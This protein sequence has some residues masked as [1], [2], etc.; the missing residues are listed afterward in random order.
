LCALSEIERN[1]ISP[2]TKEALKAR[3][4]AGVKLG[5][6]KGPGKSKLD[7]FKEEIQTLLK[8]GSR[9]NY[10]AKKYGCTPATRIW[11]HD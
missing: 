2:R 7:P 1:L 3:K 9:Q 11:D 5:R 10:I 6:P 4:E 8:T